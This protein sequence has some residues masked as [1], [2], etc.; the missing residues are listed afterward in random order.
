MNRQHF[1]L[2][3]DGVA[4]KDRRGEFPVLA[5]KHRAGA[6]QIHRHQRMQQA[7]G[8]TA[9][10]NQA[11]EFGVGNEALVK[12]QRVAIPFMQLQKVDVPFLEVFDQL[13]LTIGILR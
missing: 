1:C 13:Y 5:E 6:R 12:M 10:H 11:F 7:G 3:G 8:Q 2:G 4:D 9:L